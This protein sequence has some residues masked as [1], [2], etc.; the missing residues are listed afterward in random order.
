MRKQRSQGLERVNNLPIVTLLASHRG[1]DS[2]QVSLI[3]EL[4]SVLFHC[5]IALPMHP[6]RQGHKGYISPLATTRDTFVTTVEI[7]V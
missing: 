6:A 3:P 2:S 5:C 1:Q 4:L 7:Q